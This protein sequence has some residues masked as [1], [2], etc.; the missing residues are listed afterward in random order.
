MS[1]FIFDALLTNDGATIYVCF[2]SFF[3]SVIWGC[4]PWNNLLKMI[5][6]PMY[7]GCI[8]CFADL[9]LRGYEYD[10]FHRIKRSSNM[11]WCCKSFWITWWLTSIW[12]NFIFHYERVKHLCLQFNHFNFRFKSILVQKYIWKWSA[13]VSRSL[14]SINMCNVKRGKGKRNNLFFFLCLRKWCKG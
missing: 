12:S 1:K 7:F 5:L 14:K 2:L 13:D 8:F 11:N 6:W 9:F 3:C 10:R 4:R